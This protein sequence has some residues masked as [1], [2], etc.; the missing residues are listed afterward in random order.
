MWFKQLS[1]YLLPEMPDKQALEAALAESKFTPCLGL[2]WY[3][4]GFD[5]VVPFSSDLV[6]TS[7]DTSRICLKKEEKVLPAAVIRDALNIKIGEIEHAECR[8]VGR[9]E[10]QE[11]KNIITDDLLPRALTKCSTTTA[12]IANYFLLVDTANRTRAEVMLSKLRDAM[13]GL[14]A[15][16]PR[17]QTSPSS[18]MTEWLLNGAAGR[19]FELDCDCEL[20]GIGEAASVIR[21]S[22]KDLTAEDVINH[23]KNGMVVTQLG[24]CWKERIRFVLTQDFTLKRIQFLDVLQEEIANDGDLEGL[25]FASQAIM[26]ASMCDLINHLAKLLSGFAED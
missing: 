26:A 1:F 18:L 24:L 5:R 8:N 7:Q 6:F 17:T 25:W 11:L 2:D 9:K 23:V 21:I 13:G 4:Q 19:D 10:K 22:R 16:L 20:K 3:R 14:N 12:I 15:S